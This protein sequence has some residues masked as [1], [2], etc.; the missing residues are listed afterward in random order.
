LVCALVAAVGGLR[1]LVVEKSEKLGGTSAMSGGAVWVPAN[2]HGQAAGVPDNPAEALAYLRATA[3]AGWRETEDA[4]WAAFAE[5]AGRMLEFVEE[6][7]PL[8]FSL[9][10]E[11]D[12]WPACSA[13][14]AS[15]A[16][17]LRVSVSGR[18]YRR[19]AWRSANPQS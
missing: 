1:V 12:I 13:C 18:S 16:A 17:M 8:R 10:P 9:T 19:E 3:P 14:R 7:T 2:H 6:R 4:L 15:A 5:E 11:S